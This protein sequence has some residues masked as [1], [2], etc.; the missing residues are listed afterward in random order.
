MD[1]A[2]GFFGSADQC[3]LGGRNGMVLMYTRESIDAWTLSSSNFFGLDV[4][5]KATPHC[6]DADGDGDIDCLVGSGYWWA[7][8]TGVFLFR[9]DGVSSSGVTWTPSSDYLPSV[10]TRE[11]S[12]SAVTCD[13]DGDDQPEILVGG[14]IGGSKVI[15]MYRLSGSTPTIDN[16]TNPFDGLEF[17]TWENRVEMLGL[18]CADLGC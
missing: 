16:A 17:T 10:P 1:L 13:L 6:W 4:G 11:R 12:I 14:E 9:N 15:Q 3:I 18:E 8:P 2:G 7:E 5:W